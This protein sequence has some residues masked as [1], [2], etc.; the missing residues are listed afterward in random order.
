VTTWPVLDGD[1]RWEE[2]LD[3][4]MCRLRTRLQKRLSAATGAKKASLVAQLKEL[5]EDFQQEHARLTESDKSGSYVVA[6]AVRNGRPKPAID[7]AAEMIGAALGRVVA[8]LDAWKND[9]A[10]LAADIQVLATSTQEMLTNLGHNA[11][12]VITRTRKASRSKGGK[13]AVATKGRLKTPKKREAA[14]A[15]SERPEEI[16]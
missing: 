9:R 2:K 4:Q 5:R 14:A 16:G 11:G 13:Q 3:K 7:S 10:A 12:D 8:R 15:P 6:K 1:P